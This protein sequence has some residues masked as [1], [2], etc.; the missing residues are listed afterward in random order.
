M[1]FNYNEENCSK[2]KDL[3]ALPGAGQAADL[4]LW[5]DSCKD[6]MLS[7][8]GTLKKALQ[9]AMGHIAR[10]HFN[11]M[12]CTLEK[13]RLKATEIS[14]FFNNKFRKSFWLKMCFTLKTFHFD[15]IQM[16]G[17]IS[18]Q[19]AR[20]C[21]YL[22]TLLKEFLNITFDAKN[23]FS[24]SAFHFVQQKVNFSLIHLGI[25]RRIKKDEV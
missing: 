25:W 13:C 6:H 5:W 3:A 9:N 4:F 22:K 17:N 2:E 24:P 12:Y 15:I 10:K 8:A 23:I 19:N 20:K 1:T 11:H 14:P 16:L 21:K 18:F 7:K